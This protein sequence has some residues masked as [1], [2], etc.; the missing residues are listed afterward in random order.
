MKSTYFLENAK[1]LPVQARGAVP[2]RTQD[3]A[4]ALA[5]LLTD[6]Y[7]LYFKTK[8]VCKILADRSFYMHLPDLVSHGEEIFV[9]AGMLSECIQ[10][11][12]GTLHRWPEILL[13]LQRN[14]S[15]ESRN[16]PPCSL[17][18]E[19]LEYNKE[20]AV[21]MREIHW[22]CHEYGDADSAILLEEC[23]GETDRRIIFLARSRA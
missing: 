6:T 14:S 8:D 22:L 7:A 18:V 12:G 21:H 13:H 15:A 16:S 9:A 4:G 19:L 10:K 1:Y 5:L 17:L 2:I 20:L 11:L 3:V 23:I